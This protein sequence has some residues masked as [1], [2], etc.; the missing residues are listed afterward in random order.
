[1]VN[2]AAVHND[3]HIFNSQ[4]KR[5]VQEC[6]KIFEN[7]LIAHEMDSTEGEDSACDHE[8]PKF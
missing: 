3:C 5:E 7:N 2:Y 1:M 4:E 8:L 6:M